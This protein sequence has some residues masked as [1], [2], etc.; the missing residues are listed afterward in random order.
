MNSKQHRFHGVRPNVGICFALSHFDPRQFAMQFEV[1]L[2]ERT[3]ITELTLL[4]RAKGDI[5]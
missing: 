2:K 5:K 3:L 1:K 4:S